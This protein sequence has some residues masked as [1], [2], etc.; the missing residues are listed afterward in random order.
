ME[1]KNHLQN[2][3]HVK[4]ASIQKLFDNSLFHIAI[5]LVLLLQLPLAKCKVQYNDCKV[6]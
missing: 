4:I 5:G 2:S 1:S 3:T 6:K